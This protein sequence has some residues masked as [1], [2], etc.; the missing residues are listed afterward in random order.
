[1]L[2][3]TTAVAE[4]N[5]LKLRTSVL[6]DVSFRVQKGERIVLCGMSSEEEHE[7]KAVASGMTAFQGSILVDGTPLREMNAL[8]LSV[9]F[10]KAPYSELVTAN[11]IYVFDHGSVMQEG[12][13]VELMKQLHGKYAREIVRQSGSFAL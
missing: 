3:C 2:L 10:Q 1:M 13:H 4:M 7:L 12:R 11:K 9:Q 8:S 5:F 6:H